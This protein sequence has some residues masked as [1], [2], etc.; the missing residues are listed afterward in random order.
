MDYKINVCL[1]KERYDEKPLGNVINKMRWECKELS[2]DDFANAISQGYSFCALM[3]NNWRD[4]NNFICTSMLVFDIDHCTTPMDEYIPKLEYKPTICYTSPSNTEGDYGFRLIYLLD[5]ELC[6]VDD[7]YTFSVSFAHQSNFEQ[8]SKPSLSNKK[9]R[10]LDEHSHLGEQ[11]WNGNSH[12]EVVVYG[13]ILKKENINV[14][15]VYK[16][17]LAKKTKSISQTI[18]IHTHHN[19]VSDTFQRDY[20]NMP[21]QDFIQKYHTVY[22][23]MEHTPIDISEDEPMI[24]FNDDYYEIRRPWK[25]INGETLKIKDG[26]GRRKKLF[27]N[28]IIRRKINPSI[29]FENLLYNLVYEFEYYYINDGNTITKKTLYD[30]AD[31]VMKAKIVDSS[32]GKPKYKSK[33]NPLYCVKYGLTP[34]Q[35][36]AKLKNK[37]QY[38]GE[39]YDFEL[40]DQQNLDIMKEFGLEISLITLK[41][42][43]KENGIKKYNKN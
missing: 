27:L 24:Y 43:K 28:G 20:E 38:I 34:K 13:N 42:W 22:E 39:F 17:V 15:Q 19:R 12:G 40:T 10:I 25:K 11:F 29:T 16:R 37:K 5:F 9:K 14:N 33:V 1:S 31:N 3:Q 6:S 32:L 18:T 41:R 8:L 4:R 30:I 26:E 23:N 2:V 7:Y 21:F 36:I 35:V